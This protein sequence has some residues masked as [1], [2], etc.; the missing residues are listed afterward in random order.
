LREIHFDEFSSLLRSRG[1]DRV[2]TRRYILGGIGLPFAEK[3]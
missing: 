3:R 1:N 2:D